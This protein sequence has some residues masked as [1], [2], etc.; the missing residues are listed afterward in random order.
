[1]L[2]DLISLIDERMGKLE[3]RANRMTYHR[4]M[5]RIELIKNDP[6]YSFMFENA[7]VGGDTMAAVLSKLFSLDD[8]GKPVTV[9]RLGSLPGEAVD[10]VVCVLLRLAFEFGLWSDGTL[11]LLI[12][13]EEAH[14]YAAADRSIGFAPA[15]HSLSRIAK[16][17]RKYGVHLALVSQRP[18]ELDPTIISQCST[19]FA[20]R[21]TNEQDQALLR[22]ASA[23]VAVHLLDMVPALGTGE[24]VGI[25]EAM[26]LSTRLSFEMLAKDRLPSSE[27]A[28]V[29]PTTRSLNRSDL[30]KTVV[31]RWRRATVNQATDE[32]APAL[33]PEHSERP[34]LLR[35][36]L[37][38]SLH[39]GSRLLDQTGHRS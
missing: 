11:P 12:V 33:S 4:L 3:N 37:D 28:S 34:S 17:G 29:L 14:R 6:R 36:P 13:C 18:A 27:M 23:D 21:M 20:M 39:G 38:A 1:M 35:A 30:V 19:I 7:N 24:V 2:Q 32:E 22:S 10:A 25:G 31:D 26:P 8:D 16:E 15:R 5:G 9:L